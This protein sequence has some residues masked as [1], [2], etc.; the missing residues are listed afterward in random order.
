MWNKFIIIMIYFND[1]HKYTLPRSYACFLSGFAIVYWTHCRRTKWLFR[2]LEYYVPSGGSGEMPI[3]CSKA[4][5]SLRLRSKSE[6]SGVT[7]VFCWLSD[8]TKAIKKRCL[9]RCEY[10]IAHHSSPHKWRHAC[11]ISFWSKMPTP[12]FCT[13]IQQMFVCTYGQTQTQPF[14]CH[15]LMKS[16]QTHKQTRV[17]YSMNASSVNVLTFFLTSFFFLSSSFLFFSSLIW[18]R[19]CFLRSSSAFRSLLSDMMSYRPSRK[20]MEQAWATYGPFTTA[21][22]QH[23]LHFDMIL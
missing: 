16:S 13:H 7:S 5:V 1:I 15:G 12:T 6:S 19:R 23:E 3:L 9:T 18:A 14:M 22:S 4:S 21:P 8:C 11:V 2:V 10:I 17:G 20:N